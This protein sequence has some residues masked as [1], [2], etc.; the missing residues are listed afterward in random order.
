M[1]RARFLGLGWAAA[2]LILGAIIPPAFADWNPQDPYKWVQYPDLSPMGIDVNASAPD[3]V[4]ADDFLCTQPGPLTDIHIWGSWYHDILPNQDWPTAVTFILSIHKDIPAED[5]PDGYS[6]PGDLLWMT[7]F[8]PDS[9]AARVWEAGLLEGWLDPPGLYEFPGDTVCWQ[10]NFIIPDSEAF[11]QEGTPDVP[12]IYWL[13]VQA[14]PQDPV[15]RFGWKTSLDHWNDDA[16]W[17]HGPEPYAGP[18]Y[19]LIYPPGHEMQ[20]QSIDLA[21]VITGSDPVEE[22]D[23][24]DAP[25]PSYPTLLANDGP[26]HVIQPG[27]MLGNSIDGEA[28]GQP[29]AAATGDDLDG[30]DD[31][32]GV[33]F[34]SPIMPASTATVDVL[35][36]AGGILDAWLDFGADGSFAEPGDAIFTMQPLAPGLNSLAFVVPVGTMPNVSSFARFRLSMNGGLSWRGWA[37]DGEVEDYLVQIEEPPSSILGDRVW[38]DLDNDGIQDGGE[39]GHGNVQVDLYDS[40]G[41]LIATT[42]SAADGSYAFNGLSTDSYYLQF[43][44]P[45]GYLFSP[46][47]QGMDDLVDS[48]ASPTGTTAWIS[49]T[50]GVDDLS[51]D[52]GLY[53]PVTYKWEQPPDLTPMGIDVHCQEPFLLADDFLCTTTGPLTEIW[54]WGSWFGDYYPFGQ[55]PDQV[56]FRLSIHTDIPA[57]DNEYSRP[58]PTLWLHDAPPGTFEV[59]HFAEGP[60][61][62]LDPPDG[63]IFPADFN[64]WLYRFYID[65]S[66][67]FWQYGN[68]AEP[69]IYW[70]DVQAYPLDPEARFGWKTSVTHWNDDAVWGMGNEPYPGPWGELRYPPGHEYAGQS[71]DLAFGLAGESLEL[72]LD[73]G[74]APDPSYPTLLASNGGRHVLVSGVFL[75]NSVD[76]EPDGQPDP[77]ALGDD[78]DGNDD[79]DGVLFTSPINPGIA[80]TVDVFASTAGILDAWVDFDGDGAWNQAEER[81]FAGQPLVPGLNSLGYTPPANGLGA[82]VGFARFRYS[83]SGATF[84][85][86][87]AYGGEV[88]DY[89]VWIE[90]DVTAAPDTPPARFGLR[91]NLPNPFNPVT[92]IGYDVPTGGGQVRLAIYDLAG[93][94]VLTL[95]DGPAAEGRHQAIWRGRDA[96]GGEM[97]SGVYFAR[98]QAPGCDQTV[99]MLLLR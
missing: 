77:G 93:R 22:L 18:W 98:F 15:A 42:F 48:D 92:M 14:I 80:S 78:N 54:I 4:L 20:G 74:D 73:Y 27:F 29:S 17:G 61:G 31:E 8:Q 81:I 46:Q 91:Q 52:A 60:E 68:E 41:T 63:Y 87:T 96:A 43:T 50:G 33:T 49:I 5:N 30:N 25:D 35:A 79:E 70:L 64:C 67:A 84:P 57:T 95:L 21:F 85:T 51:W 40:G 19:E 88:E 99:K 44:A 6:M 9:Y 11:W 10:Y 34:T 47:D 28:D 3:Y 62:W 83:L 55:I 89:E 90:D 69:M 59:F 76:S 65:P 56:G 45:A 72:S 26:R 86:G 97:P 82:H 66:D 23:F 39:P 58:G 37:P 36:P 16:V 32:D 7:T 75:G 1:R 2:I 12:V 71:L 38:D 94:E 13:D 53:L 24:G